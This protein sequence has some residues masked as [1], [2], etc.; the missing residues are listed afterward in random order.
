VERA[1]RSI[2]QQVRVM[3]DALEFKARVKIGCRHPVM[4][5]IVEYAGHLLNRFEI[6]QD[7]KSAYERCKGKSARTLGIEFGESVHWKRKPVGGALAKATCLWEDG[8]F[9]GIRGA[10]G[11]IIVGDERGVWKTRSVQRKP[12]S[13]RWA[14]G[15]LEAVRHVPW[16]VSEEDPNMDGERLLVED[17]GRKLPE[18]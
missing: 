11:E 17:L 15:C 5:W 13:E 16:R 7:G 10:S 12:L 8:I 14:D 2:Q 6:G 3:K 9:L 1:I 18:A 4:P